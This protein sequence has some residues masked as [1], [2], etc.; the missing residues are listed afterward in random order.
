[1]STIRSI[2]GG[3]ATV[4][5]LTSC[6]LLQP[7]PTDEPSLAEPTPS[8]EAAEPKLSQEVWDSAVEGLVEMGG[9]H[10][11][12]MGVAEWPFTGE[13]VI[14]AAFP[15][16]A[17]GQMEWDWVDSTGEVRESIALGAG[18]DITVPLSDY[19]YQQ[20]RD[21]LDDVGE[22]G[23]DEVRMWAA[24]PMPSGVWHE[25]GGCAAEN[26]V[27]QDRGATPGLYNVVPTP[28]VVRLD[29]EPVP[30][31]EDWASPEGLAQIWADGQ[32]AMGEALL[33]GISISPAYGGISIVGSNGTECGGQTGF[34]FTRSLTPSD[35]RLDLKPGQG[36]LV[37]NCSQGSDRGFRFTDVT[38]EEVAEVAA[39]AIKEHGLDLDARTGH[40]AIGL[41]GQALVMMIGQDRA[42]SHSYVLIPDPAATQPPA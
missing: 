11:V 4:L 7:T 18:G 42:V 24:R 28:Q 26:R 19:S 27:A 30:D 14:A 20:A 22:C 32:A 6:S 2:L 9:V 34:V 15:G 16:A 17:L 23:T 37:A 35:A 25:Y 21:F 10:A 1:M 41:E 5:L 33:R 12:W 3:V 36:G 39:E 13:Y 29:G 31:L 8:P 38:P 40:L